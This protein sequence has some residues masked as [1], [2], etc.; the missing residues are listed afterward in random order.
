M[1]E[2]GRA[3]LRGLSVGLVLGLFAPIFTPRDWQSWLASAP[4]DIA[5]EKAPAVQKAEPKGTHRAST[6]ALLRLLLRAENLLRIGKPDAAVRML[7]G[8]SVEGHHGN[9][10]LRLQSWALFMER[11]HAEAAELLDGEDALSAELIF[12][13]GASR[14]RVGSPGAIEDLRRLWWENPATVWGLS[15]LRELAT[16]SVRDGGPYPDDHR[17]LILDRIDPPDL[18]SAVDAERRIEVTLTN[19][20]NAHR[21]AGLLGA[22]L[23]HA[24]GILELRREEFT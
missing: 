17:A 13:R 9:D 11:R 7:R 22:E 6:D 2:H 5:A 21:E 24:W 10:L 12:I 8:L 1:G 18:D 20:A 15:A 3:A 19:L 23:N 4:T 14:W 16:R